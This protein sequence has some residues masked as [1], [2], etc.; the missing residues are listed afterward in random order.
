MK[1]CTL[2]KQTSNDNHLIL[3]LQN[4]SKWFEAYHHNDYY[5]YFTIKLG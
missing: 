1:S 5:M 4:A 2:N 3:F